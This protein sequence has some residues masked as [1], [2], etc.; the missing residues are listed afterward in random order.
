MR[1]LLVECASLR[2][3]QHLA[4]KLRRQH[5]QWSLELLRVASAAPKADP[6]SAC[7]ERCWTL[8]DIPADLEWDLV[9]FPLVSRGFAR[10]KI[11]A[12][13]IPA[14]QR[15]SVDFSG[16][17]HDCSLR[18]LLTSVLK[19]PYALDAERHKGGTPEAAGQ[20][21]G[22]VL[23]V[24]SASRETVERTRPRWSRRLDPQAEVKAL[25]G[26]SLFSKWRV[27][28]RERFSGAIL[29]LDGR[30]GFF[31]L[32]LIPWLLG[33]DG[34][35]AVDETGA[36]F[37]VNRS[38]LVRHLFR[39][40]WHG[41]APVRE[42]RRIL[43]LQT[44]T[45]RYMLEAARRIR[46][47]R[48]YPRAE[49]LL[50]CSERHRAEFSESA[51]F[52]RV[53]SAPARPSVSELWQIRRR[54]WEFD[55]EAICC[56]Y[57]HRPIFRKAKA[58]FLL[59][60]FRR[61]LVFD[62]ALECYELSVRTA[63]K[64]GRKKPLLFES[65][66]HPEEAG[67]RVAWIHSGTM[68][69]CR[70]ALETIRKPEVA[71]HPAFTVICPRELQEAYAEM[72]GVKR[73][74][75]YESRR[76]VSFLRA[77]R[78]LAEEQPNA[79]AALFTR[80]RRFLQQKLLFLLL[81]GAARL[82]FNRNLDCFFLRRRRLGETIRLFLES[83]PIHLREAQRF[84]FLETEGLEFCGQLL[85]S[86]HHPKIAPNP[87][88]TVYCNESRRHFFESRPDVERIVPYSSGISFQNLLGLRKLVKAD[89]EVV[90]AALT[91]RPIFRLQKLIFFLYP[92]RHR[93]A[94]NEHLHCHYLNSS[95]AGSLLHRRR[96]SGAAFSLGRTILKGALFLPRFIYLLGWLAFEKRKRTRVLRRQ[97]AQRSG[98]ASS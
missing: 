29:F 17:I 7:F 83:T 44:E 1:V 54:V 50:L 98:P 20:L 81:P 79:V 34:V 67:L 5:P 6:A 10:V 71:N 13:R 75:S 60:G 91:G 94:F 30:P 21:R 42:V 77:A 45:P 27:L 78:K 95:S 40:F 82:A 41:R 89:V 31:R 80:R 12:W 35:V 90:T 59:S 19:P 2:T 22:R 92:V 73:V 93:L 9:L 69:E 65:E 25:E 47:A 49:L 33:I 4:R 88:I 66:F 16:R 58:Y 57:S 86:L 53:L 46:S 23:L 64:L 8:S 76:S 70:R 63:G 87:R 26:G 84:L 18:L 11:A 61:K 36:S 55:P 28:R 32:K 97:E 74:L 62:S 56:V 3:L 14:K 48:L 38:S 39:R 52:S 43:L 68:E 37:E 72:E 51:E 24:K 15:K 96:S 85:D